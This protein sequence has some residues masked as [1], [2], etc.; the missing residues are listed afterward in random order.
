MEA[1]ILPKIS[2]Q[3]FMAALSARQLQAHEKVHGYT[4]GSSSTQ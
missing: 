4:D 3:M 2:T 1:D